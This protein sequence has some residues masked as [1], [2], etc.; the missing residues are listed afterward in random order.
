MPSN[1]SVS[2]APITQFVNC[3]ILREHKLQREDLWVREGKILDPE[4]LF[5]DEKGSADQ[6]V[7]CEGLIIAPG[8]IDVQINGGYGI[9]FSQATDDVRGGIALVAKK[10]L[11]HGVT[12]FLPTLVTSPPDIYHKVLP[13]VKVHSG[14]MEG[15]GVLGFHLE[16]PFISLEK[17]GAHPEQHLRSFLSDGMSD[18]IETYG[19]LD[20]VA[21]VTLAP[22]LPNSQSVVREL[23]QRG[24]TVSLGHSVANLSQAEDAVRYGASFITHLFN[25]MLPFH[26]RDPGIVGLLTSDQVP[27]GRTV[28]YG[29]IADGIHTNPAALR[30][31]H[32]AHP[33][34]LV[35]V[36]D[37]IAA[38][39]LP[40]GRHTLGQQ[41]IEIQGLHAYVAGTKTLCGSI[42]TM[43]MCVRHFKQAS[44]CRVEE[45]LEAASLHPAQL[46]GISHAKGIL[47]YGGDA[48]LVLLDDA[49][50]VRATYIAGQEVWRKLHHHNC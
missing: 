19:T 11:E 49:L 38:M 10:I 36:T 14:G 35:L 40:P 21:M 43:D 50:N 7:D 12:S 37:A 44:G 45:A 42:A 24:I 9:D 46:L 5:F 33:T 16:G 1:K 13:E 48:D 6:R 32:R 34:G 29:M 22:E 30:I 26:H 28:F 18:L 41:V 39:G 2:D 8:F 3:R 31:A 20:N 27:Q 15:A 47:D 25:A 17:K 23:T 4:K